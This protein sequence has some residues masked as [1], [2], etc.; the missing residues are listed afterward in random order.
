MMAPHATAWAAGREQGVIWPGS[1][2]R[3][4]T[5]VIDFIAGLYC[6]GDRRRGWRMATANG[7]RAR[8]V[9]IIPLDDTP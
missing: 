7:W 5:E 9:A 2:R 3:T 4:R 8:R 6:T 1:V